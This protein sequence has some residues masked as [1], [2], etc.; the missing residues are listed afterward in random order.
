M[1][2]EAPHAINPRPEALSSIDTARKNQVALEHERLIEPIA[3]MLANRLPTH[4]D[5]QDLIQIGRL[6]L[7]QASERYDSNPEGFISYAKFRIRGAMLDFVRDNYPVRAVAEEP[8]A[9]PQND[10]KTESPV[11]EAL[12]RAARLTRG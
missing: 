7:L 8:A 1:R 4:F 2:C 6:A 5:V 11:R 10:D 12:S 9:A 3:R